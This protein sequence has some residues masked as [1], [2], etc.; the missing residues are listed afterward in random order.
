MPKKLFVAIFSLAIINLALFS[1]IISINRNINISEIPQNVIELFTLKRKSTTIER[2]SPLPS[3]AEPLEDLVISYSYIDQSNPSPARLAGLNRV[4]VENWVIKDME[5]G[6]ESNSVGTLD[7]S[8]R[9]QGRKRLLSIPILDEIN[10]YK[11]ENGESYDAGILSVF[12]IELQ[13]GDEINASVVFV[14]QTLLNGTKQLELYCL[15]GYNRTCA[16]YIP[17]GFGSLPIDFKQY[18]AEI[19]KNSDSAVLDLRKAVPSYLSTK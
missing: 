2:P 3:P 15:A 18:L 12:D 5:I 14:P 8:F 10:I 17:L 19:Y 7:V 6:S 13:K 9:Y 11:N 4:K 1:Y 16:K